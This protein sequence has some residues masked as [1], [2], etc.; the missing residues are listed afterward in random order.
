MAARLRRETTLTIQQIADRLRMGG[1][2][3]IAPKLHDWIKTHE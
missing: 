1:R 2:K 3:S